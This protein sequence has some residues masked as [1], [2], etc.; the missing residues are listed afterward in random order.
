MRKVKVQPGQKRLPLVIRDAVDAARNI[1]GLK[2]GV[3]AT[4]AAIVSFVDKQ[5]PAAIVF[6]RKEKIAMRADCTDRT[7]RRHL[8]ELEEAGFI[9]CKEQEHAQK[10][11]QFKVSHI[12]LT[13][14]LKEIIGLVEEQETYPQPA[15]KFS[16]P[17]DEMSGAPN[18]GLSD[19]SFISN[20]HAPLPRGITVPAD[21]KFLTDRMHAWGVFSLMKKAR[22]KGK[23][24]SDVATCSR[25]RVEKLNLK[26]GRLYSYLLALIVSAT[27]FV[28]PAKEAKAQ[29]C[30][31]QAVSL[32][33]ARIESARARWKGKQYIAFNKETARAM[34]IFRFSDD[35]NFVELYDAETN[36]FI[37]TQPLFTPEQACKVADLLDN[38]QLF[39]S[40]TL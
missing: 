16:A 2:R 14:K 3:R 34:T 19:P 36:K 28:Y 29:Q 32:Q 11:G 4:L 9:E 18:I 40:T 17:K 20:R 6:A 10:T 35:G 27:C 7:I 23:R 39:P 1:P 15:E 31:K 8:R 25:A 24:L 26:G 30:E 38:G 12:Q 13:G 37:G 5:D 33:K 22:E 21:L